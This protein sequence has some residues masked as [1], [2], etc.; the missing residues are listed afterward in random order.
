MSPTHKRNPH[1]SL[2]LAHRPVHHTQATHTTLL[3]PT[4]RKV[5]PLLEC[6]PSITSHKH[7][8]FSPCRPHT[9]ATLTPLLISLTGPFT[10]HKPRIPHFCT[11]LPARCSPHW[12]ASH[13]SPATNT[14]L[15]P[16]VAHTQTQPSPLS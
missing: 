7:T 16:H 12:S 13:P 14:L 1:P 10:T 11:P 5:F 6:I 9:N 15:S 4:A 3:H 2:D 8:T